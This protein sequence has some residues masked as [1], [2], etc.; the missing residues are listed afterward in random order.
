MTTSLVSD[1]QVE[2]FWRDGVLCLRGLFR[3]WVEPMRVAIDEVL[4]EPGALTLDLGAGAGSPEQARNDRFYIELGL[5]DRHPWFR[6]LATESPAVEIA[7]R[8][9]GGKGVNLFFDQL[10]VKEPGSGQQ[11][12]P[13]HQD[14]PYWPIRGNDIVSVWVTADPVTAETGALRY[15][16][17]SHRWD[18]FY[19]PYT[20][21]SKTV[22]V[23][24]IDGAEIPDIDAQPER[25]EFLTWDLEPGDCLVHQ[26][27]AIHGGP[28]NASLTQRRRAYS[29]RYAGDDIRWD[30][31]PGVLENI[32][33]MTTRPITL[34]DGDRLGGEAFP[35]LR[36]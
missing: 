15:V 25:Y 1:A 23:R 14:Q 36:G 13:W 22:A 3:D 30:P 20:F 7:D 10:F 16:R 2:Q 5:W 18:E 12:T 6:S 19:R 8:I 9:L 26:G 4:A 34:A 27:R 17:G 28:G 35:R 32:T 31:R 21:G 33:V 24:G 29:I 11:R